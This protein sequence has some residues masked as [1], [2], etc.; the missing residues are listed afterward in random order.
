MK[1]VT[2]ALQPMDAPKAEKTKSS[3]HLKTM[4]TAPPSVDIT[5]NVPSIA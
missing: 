4:E 5:A 3:V 1:D 2:N